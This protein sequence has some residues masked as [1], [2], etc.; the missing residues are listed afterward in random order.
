[1]QQ[2]IKIH[3]EK[4]PEDNSYKFTEAFVAQWF[5]VVGNGRGNTSPN[6]DH[7]CLRFSLL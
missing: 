7:G 3:L 6:S 2:N 5:I 1:M 4:N